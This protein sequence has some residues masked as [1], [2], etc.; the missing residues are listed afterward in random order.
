MLELLNDCADFTNPYGVRVVGVASSQA[1]SDRLSQFGTARDYH[2]FDMQND[3]NWYKDKEDDCDFMPPCLGSSEFYDEPSEDKFVMTFQKQDQCVNDSDFKDESDTCQ[4]M[5][6]N[7]HDDKLWSFPPMDYA[8]DSVEIKDYY[9]LNENSYD[10]D[11]IKNDKNSYLDQG[12]HDE[13]SEIQILTSF[14]ESNF[15]FKPT[16][17]RQN[18]CVLDVEHETDTSCIYRDLKSTSTINDYID[19][20]GYCESRKGNFEGE[21]NNKVNKTSYENDTAGDEGGSATGDE[22]VYDTN[23][24][25]YEVFSLR[26]I[27]RK[28]RFENLDLLFISCLGLIHLKSWGKIIHTPVYYI[29]IHNS[30]RW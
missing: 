20:E 9:D 24:E 7:N 27:H 12:Y 1:S 30:S 13:D 6:E 22:L 26:I 10:R 18:E 28:N 15:H 3:L 2:D 23:E 5:R 14:N 25:D 8:K 21:D 4:S 17:D 29:S 19:K 16:G 11:E